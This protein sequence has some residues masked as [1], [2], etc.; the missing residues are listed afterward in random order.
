MFMA[1]PDGMGTK[2]M[3]SL[4]LGYLFGYPLLFSVSFTTPQTVKVKRFHFN[5]KSNNISNNYI[6]HIIMNNNNNNN[7]DDDD[8]DDD[9]SKA[10]VEFFPVRLTFLADIFEF[11]KTENTFFFLKTENSIKAEKNSTCRF[12]TISIIT[13]GN[14]KKNKNKNFRVFFLPHSTS[15]AEC[16]VG[17]GGSMVMLD[18]CIFFY[19]LYLFG[20]A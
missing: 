15:A 3:Q 11:M 12:V 17:G 5:T 20:L 1:M 14:N 16:P 18:K 2:Y 10:I 13:R 6:D 7:N 4:W 9:S 8:D 19:L